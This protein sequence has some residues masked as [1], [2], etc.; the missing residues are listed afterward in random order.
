MQGIL[1]MNSA[2]EHAKYGSAITHVKNRLRIHSAN[3]HGWS[4]SETFRNR[5][6]ILPTTERLEIFEARLAIVALVPQGETAELFRI[7]RDRVPVGK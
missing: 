2:I 7:A 5:V 1:S 4:G 3:G 6:G